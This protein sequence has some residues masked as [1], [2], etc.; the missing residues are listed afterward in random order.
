[1]PFRQ[2]AVVTS[3]DLATG[4]INL[5]QAAVFFDQVH[6]VEVPLGEVHELPLIVGPSYDYLLERGLL[7]RSHWR[8]EANEK[9]LLGYQVRSI[10]S[11][12]VFT[13]ERNKPAYW[14]YGCS[15]LVRLAAARLS[16]RDPDRTYVPITQTSFFQSKPEMVARF[17]AELP[18][19]PPKKVQ[20]ITW[21]FDQVPAPSDN[22]PWEDIFDYRKDSRT[23]GHCLQLRRW[24]Q[25]NADASN[26]SELA[27]SLQHDLS[28]LEERMR[29]HRIKSTLVRVDATLPFL[30]ILGNLLTLRFGDL[31]RP[32]VTAAKS[33]IDL[34]SAELALT[35][36][37]L[38]M[39]ADIRRRLQG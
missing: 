6:V 24:I 36:D 19:T 30:N 14:E 18:S 15:G 13:P 21:T 12:S 29:F 16:A 35:S 25:K 5:K 17:E 2:S 27:E 23:Q 11:A 39:M 9:L 26:A 37:P 33:E 28:L 8:E 3:L 38:Y 1:M 20:A 34:S 4:R 32:A 22:T 10:F 7:T 31:V